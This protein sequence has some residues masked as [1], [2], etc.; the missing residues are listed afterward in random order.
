MAQRGWALLI[1]SVFAGPAA[2]HGQTESRGAPQAGW[3]E[4][5]KCEAE[6]RHP[7]EPAARPLIEKRDQYRFLYVGD[8]VRCTKTGRL[9]VQV[10]EHLIRIEATVGWCTI[11]SDSLTCK[12]GASTTESHSSSP[13]AQRQRAGQDSRPSVA[14]REAIAGFGR[15]AGRTRGP[16]SAIISPAM[17][18]AIRI[19]R[20]AIRWTA[21]A[22]A[23]GMVRLRLTDPGDRVL[24]TSDPIDAQARSADAAPARRA[25]EAYR[26][27]GSGGELTLTLDGAAAST[28]A[29]LFTVLSEADERNL[30]AA[31]AGCQARG[32]FMQTVCRIHQFSMRQMWNAA[33]DEYEQALKA[34]PG[35]EQL[36]R[37][38]L[39]A[40]QRIGDTDRVTQLAA[41]LPQNSRGRR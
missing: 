5:I 41:E 3:I 34:S 10:Y 38:A 16:A 39:A 33:T 31:L 40:N 35:S 6:L 23:K 18:S 11:G 2:V 27:S 8:E 37:A 13:T 30:D 28:P 22:A 15:T 9:T 1:V 17:D 7:L 21:A 29:V 36:T 20:L 26:R 32:G 14:D 4:Q 24:W 25:L 19:D 12:D